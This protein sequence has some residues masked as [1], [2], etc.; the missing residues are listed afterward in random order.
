VFFEVV[1]LLFVADLV[2]G[3]VVALGAGLLSESNLP[4][5]NFVGSFINGAQTYVVLPSTRFSPLV[6]HGSPTLIAAN[7]LFGVTRTTAINSSNKR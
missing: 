5:I 4:H 2:V 3:L 1:D 6:V 7:E